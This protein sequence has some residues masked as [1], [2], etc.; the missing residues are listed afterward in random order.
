L[1]EEA[2]LPET[3]RA[4]LAQR[5]DGEIEF[6][7]VDGGSSDSTLAILD[8]FAARDPRVRVLH[9]P[10]RRTT[11]ALNIA[12]QNARGEFVAR[13]DAHSRYPADYVARGVARLLEG[14]VDWVSGPAIAEGDGRW[15]RPIAAALKT[16]L[17]QGGSR[18]WAPG[19]SEVEL[20]TG[21]FTGIWRRSLLEALGGWDEDWPVNQDSEMAARV[22]ERGGRIVC[23]PELAA[24]YSPRNSPASLARQYWRYGY[25]RTKTA[26]RH[27]DAMRR[28]HVLVPG[29]VLA[30]AASVAAPRRIRSAARAAIALYLTALIAV[31]AR[32]AQAGDAEPPDVMLMPVVLAIMHLAWGGGFIAASARFGPPV[33]ALR[34]VTR[35]SRGS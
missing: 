18:K 10:A 27:P 9:N 21:V 26:Q 20:D 16:P 35:R 19:Q 28:S 34:R 13:M 5:F 7:F 3:M 15:S 32:T 6:L 2:H 30:F 14:D 31:S 12:L 23:R 17:G 33:E 24:F 22:F 4:M 1:N 11:S 25:Y 8:E 29:L